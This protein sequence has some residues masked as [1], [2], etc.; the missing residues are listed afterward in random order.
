MKITKTK[1][2][3]I[4]QEEVKALLNEADWDHP[5]MVRAGEIE[6]EIG[7]ERLNAIRSAIAASQEESLSPEDKRYAD[8]LWALQDPE[9]PEESDEEFSAAVDDLMKDIHSS[10]KDPEELMKLFLSHRGM[11]K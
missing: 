6:D 9:S 1:L 8:E 11:G 5:A 4:I 2:K 10:E 3:Q 7:E